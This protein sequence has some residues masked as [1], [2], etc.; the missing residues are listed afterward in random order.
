MW[1]RAS[2]TMFAVASAKHQLRQTSAVNTNAHRERGG[3]K[4]TAGGS[5]RQI[6]RGRIPELVASALVRNAARHNTR[7]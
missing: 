4:W 5:R 6:G 1:A 2:L 7:S 3:H